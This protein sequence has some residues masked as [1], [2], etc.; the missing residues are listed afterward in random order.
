ML[1]KPFTP[2]QIFSFE[3]I[4]DKEGYL[5]CDTSAVS[6]LALS[7]KNVYQ[8]KSFSD[9]SLDSIE[10]EI[11]KISIFLEFMENP[12][13]LLTSKVSE[14]IRRIRDRLGTKIH[15][16]RENYNLRRNGR[17]PCDEKPIEQIKL[18]EIHELYNELHR[19]SRR[20]VF[21]PGQRQI[22]SFLEKIVLSVTR[23][24]D[25]KIDYGFFYRKDD[26]PRKRED[27]HTDEQLVATALYLSA[28]ERRRGGIL[29]RDSDIK[30][31]LRNTLFYLNNSGQQ[32]YV[33][34]VHLLRENP[35]SLYH[36][37]ENKE[38][39]LIIDS[40]WAYPFEVNN[41]VSPEKIRTISVDL[42]TV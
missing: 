28:F 30:R 34:I 35:I 22:Y 32:G 9:F 38:A 12:K 14:E 17:K 13:I 19:A 42:S 11:E 31:I 26:K 18:E 20:S 27:P 37:E 6:Q 40:S 29:T 15:F 23:N 25:A 7:S 41:I 3:K 33:E 24:T 16:L 8:T 2:G 39:R 21:F 36:V 4:I 5:I 10:G 1:K